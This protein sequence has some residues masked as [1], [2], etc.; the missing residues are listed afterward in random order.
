MISVSIHIEYNQLKSSP[1]KSETRLSHTL[2]EKY[3][4]TLVNVDLTEYWINRR[5]VK[6]SGE[7]WLE[8]GQSI[9]LSEDNVDLPSTYVEFILYINRFPLQALNSQPFL[10]FVNR[11]GSTDRDPFYHQRHSWYTINFNW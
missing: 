6:L 8:N 2:T 3:D 5:S 4:F 1:L 10:H 11:A 7:N 9:E